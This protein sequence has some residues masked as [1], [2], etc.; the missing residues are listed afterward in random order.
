[1]IK[2]LLSLLL[3]GTKIF[4]AIVFFLLIA[5]LLLAT[6]R[7]V[8][9]NPTPLIIVSDLRSETMPFE[10]SPERGRYALLLSMVENH[11]FIFTKD[12]A[13][14]AVPDLGSIG[15]KYVSLFAPGVSLIAI[16][17][18]L[19][20][21]S[22]GFAQIGAF[23]VSGFFALF[24]LLLIALI[25]K[26]ISGNGFAGL[27]GGLTFLFA[28]AAWPYAG[29]L[30]Q[31]HLSAFL[32]LGA[33]YILLFP[34][35]IMR[36]ILFGFAFGISL[37]IDYPNGI[38]F[39]PLLVFLFSK[40]LQFGEH[41]NRINIIFSFSVFLVIIGII[42]GLAPSLWYNKEAYGNPFQLAGTL[43]SV[44]T[45]EPSATDLPEQVQ[46]SYKKKTALGFFKSEHMAQGFEVLLTS[47][48]RGI[49]FFSPVIL[50][51]LLG[52]IPLLRK[53]SDAGYVILAQVGVFLTLYS[54]WGD[55]WGGWAFGPRYL[56]PMFG[57]LGVGLGVAIHEYGKKLV[58]M[59]VYFILLNYSLAISLTGA[60]TTN[61]IP[62]GIESS[63]A[64]YPAYTFLYNFSLLYSGVSGSYVY[65][66][67]FRN[68]LSLPYFAGGLFLIV[69]TL[70]TI[71]YV[72]SMQNKRSSYL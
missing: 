46:I 42:I 8:G 50:L 4:F 11:S 44:R 70:I 38:F 25:V 45:L 34:R 14:I 21:K 12:I 37:F 67:F 7:G 51:G 58:F 47:R 48:D 41:E 40:H 49:L 1:M 26:K 31:H 52:C 60:L 66:T 55:P 65:N 68:I 56:I 71:F 3:H 39:L 16:P 13:A 64:L 72:Q 24:N 5:I 63:A 2:K 27:T 9:G 32:L 23:S 59:L 10:L 19:L 54:L 17:F 33:F 28:T 22:V 15:G 29:T 35:H 36:T 30:Y 53:K 43:K 62:P 6:L 20:G 57:F 18:Y 69:S 61:Q